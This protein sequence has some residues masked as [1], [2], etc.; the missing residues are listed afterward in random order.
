MRFRLFF[1]LLGGTLA[2][3][4]PSASAPAPAT[5]H[6]TPI[7]TP[8]DETPEP[9]VAPPPREP[10]A[11]ET[12]W[13]TAFPT[14]RTNAAPTVADSLARLREQVPEAATFT[15][16]FAAAHLAS[17]PVAAGAELLE[18]TADG[19]TATAR[20]APALPSCP[21][22]NASPERRVVLFRVAPSVTAAKVVL[23]APAASCGGAVPVRPL[24]KEGCVAPAKAT[25]LTASALGKCLQNFNFSQG[26]ALALPVP[27]GYRVSGITLACAEG[28]ARPCAATRAQVSWTSTTPCPG[29]T[30]QPPIPVATPNPPASF[31]FY[32]V[33]KG[34]AILEGGTPPTLQPPRYCPPVP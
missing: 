23:V 4:A 3:C 33:P 18:V 12:A 19:T 8:T 31:E 26:T 34:I 16:D 9:A 27:P 6:A 14:S 7:V 15:Y 24:A 22:K 32:E 10:Q 11:T 28:Q 5:V 2:A 25:L 13:T 21:S 1:P 20:I 17:F 29:G 30:P